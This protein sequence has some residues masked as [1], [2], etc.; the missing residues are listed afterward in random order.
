MNARYFSPGQT[1]LFIRL[2]AI[3]L[4]VINNDDIFGFYLIINNNTQFNST[5]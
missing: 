3:K 1:Q 4:V 5:E 2:I